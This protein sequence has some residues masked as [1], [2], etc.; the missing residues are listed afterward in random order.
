MTSLPGALVVVDPARVIPPGATRLRDL[1]LS[2]GLE[3]QLFVTDAGDVVVEAW[4][5]GPVPYVVGDPVTIALRIAWVGQ[6]AQRGMLYDASPYGL[7]TNV[8]TLTARLREMAYLQVRVECLTCGWWHQS[9]DSRWTG[10]A[11]VV[12]ETQ[13]APG[14]VVIG[15]PPVDSAPSEL[16]REVKP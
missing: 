8:T 11:A 12:H 13:L 4:K 15:V 16:P 9:G 10:G 6:R 14:H 1:A 3:A 5:R 2:A 7:T